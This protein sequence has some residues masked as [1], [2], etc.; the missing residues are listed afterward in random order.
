[1]ECTS[2]TI[3]GNSLLLTFFPQEWLVD[4]SALSATTAQ[5]TTVCYANAE[6]LTLNKYVFL[7][8]IQG[9]PGG[10]DKT[11]GECSLC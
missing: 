2:T 11:S 6:R 5:V 8:Y 4:I 1:M 9:V 3:V 7:I 10:M